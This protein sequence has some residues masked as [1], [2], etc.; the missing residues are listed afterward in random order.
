MSAST[1]KILVTVLFVVVGLPP[2]LCAL[3]FTPTAL[4]G[5]QATSADG[6]A[7][8][9]LVVVPCLI[10]FVVFGGLLWLL[11]WAW[12]REAP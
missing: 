9:M 3:Y 8:A 2:G 5:L 10:G 7:Y 11:I 12:R 4:Q 1:Q 6:R